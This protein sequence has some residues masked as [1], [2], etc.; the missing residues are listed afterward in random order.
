MTKTKKKLG[1][2]DDLEMVKNCRHWPQMVLPLKKAKFYEDPTGK[3]MGV[4]YEEP[5]D[6]GWRIIHCNMWAIGS[7]SPEAWKKLV[8]EATVYESA[9]ALIADGWMV[10]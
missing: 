2:G 9:E 3:S 7:Y 4:L 5:R 10:D 1:P 6:R 8:A